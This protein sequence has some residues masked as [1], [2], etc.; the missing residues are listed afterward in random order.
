MKF[1]LIFILVMLSLVVN[2]ADARARRLRERLRSQKARFWS[3]YDEAVMAVIDELE[4]W[5]ILK[6]EDY[7][8][9]KN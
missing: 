3:K 6:Y 5:G 1:N 8:S 2:E 7:G 4:I 9:N